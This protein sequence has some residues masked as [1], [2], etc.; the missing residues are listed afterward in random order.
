MNWKKIFAI[1]RREYVETRPDQG[2]LVR[3][4]A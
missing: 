4:A 3:D 1:A 2:V